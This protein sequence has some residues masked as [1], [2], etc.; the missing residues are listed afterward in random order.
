MAL[1]L[2]QSTSPQF[3]GFPSFFDAKRTRLAARY[4]TSAVAASRVRG[5][6]PNRS[7]QD[8]GAPILMVQR[9]GSLALDAAF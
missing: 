6:P 5:V 2:L 8:C 4:Q 7:G 9:I 1:E 3:Q